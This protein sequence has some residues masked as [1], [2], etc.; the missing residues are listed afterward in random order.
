VPIVAS[1]SLRKTTTRAESVISSI[2]NTG[3]KNSSF[4]VKIFF[5]FC[6]RSQAARCLSQDK[7]L[8][9]QGILMTST[10]VGHDIACGIAITGQCLYD[11]CQKAI[12]DVNGRSRGIEASHSVDKRQLMH[13]TQ[14]VQNDRCRTRTTSGTVHKNDRTWVTCKRIDNECTPGGKSASHA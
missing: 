3:R 4:F 13:S 7:L 11:A 2:Q 14:V 6:I 1:I 12:V 10:L 5:S 8:E 9:Q